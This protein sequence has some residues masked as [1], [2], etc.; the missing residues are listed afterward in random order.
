MVISPLPE[1][2]RV[3]FL[4][5]IRDAAGSLWQNVKRVINTPFGQKTPTPSPSISPTRPQIEYA[6]NIKFIGQNKPQGQV[7]GVAAM[8]SA[9][10]SMAPQASPLPSSSPIARN[11]MIDRFNPQPNV[12]DAITQAAQKFGLPPQL[13]FDIAISESSLSPTPPSNPM[14]TAGGLFQFLD[15]SWKQVM[16]EMGLSENTPKTDPVANAM[17]AA[18]AISRQRLGWWDESKNKWGQFYSQDELSPYYAGR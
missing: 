1:P 6:P 2:D 17:A 16:R 18:H 5:T 15:S 12:I 14:S 10:P 9:R 4:S 7:R 13:L 11:P 8:A 3:D